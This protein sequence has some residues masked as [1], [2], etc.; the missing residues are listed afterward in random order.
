MLIRLKCLNAN[1][2]RAAIDVLYQTG[3]KKSIDVVAVSE[4]NI[5]V[6]QNSQWIVDER[7]DLKMRC[8]SEAVPIKRYSRG[9][10]VVSIIIYTCYISPNYN[11]RKMKLRGFE[12]IL[13]LI[14]ESVGAQTKS[15]GI[16]GDF[17]FKSSEWKSASSDE[18]G[19]RL[20][21]WIARNE[22]VVQNVGKKTTF[23]KAGMSSIIDIMIG[24]E[25]ISGKIRD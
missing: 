3:Q 22:L 9:S 24:S 7:N 21:G 12:S 11:R 18:R 4:L 1:R 10:V 20:A 23:Q 6:V 8:F 16:M 2:S 17:K 5:A 14:N 25:R 19:K 15:L 13:N